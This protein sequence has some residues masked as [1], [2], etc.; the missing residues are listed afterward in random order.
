MP[1]TVGCQDRATAH[2]GVRWVNRDSA[3]SSNCGGGL[4]DGNIAQAVQ[5]D[6]ATLPEPPEIYGIAG[7]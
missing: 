4:C 3:G 1:K 7:D 6:N 2:T 5:P